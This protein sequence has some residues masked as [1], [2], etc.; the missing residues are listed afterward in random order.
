MSWE[1]TAIELAKWAITAV[2][3][4]LLF[5]TA[6]EKW[7]AREKRKRMRRQLYEGIM[8]SYQAFWERIAI[9]TSTEGLKQGTPFR[10]K[11]KLNMYLAAWENYSSPDNKSLFFSLDEAVTLQNIYKYFDALNFVNE[12]D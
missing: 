12:T 7:D 10:F 4:G 5:K 3:G 8:L 11:D 6:L 2:G 9:A 1:N